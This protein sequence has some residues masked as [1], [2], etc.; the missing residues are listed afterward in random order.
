MP[1]SQFAI[2][3]H[4][5]AVLAHDGGGAPIEALAESVNTETAY[6]EGVLAS[7]ARAG[8]VEARAA[9]HGGGYVLAREAKAISLAA[10]HDALEPE[11]ESV[12]LGG[13]ATLRAA[14]R[15]VLGELAPGDDPR[16]EL[17][18]FTVADLTRMAFGEKQLPYFDARQFTAQVEETKGAVLVDFTATWCGPCQKLT[19]VLEELARDAGGKYRVVR[20]DIDDA[21][22]VA[23]KYSIRGVPTVVAFVDGKPVARNVGL[24]DAGKLRRL[25]DA[26]S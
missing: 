7:L 25:F 17:A 9:G 13:R 12:A 15:D 26:T 21:P 16:K 2:A 20:V 14:I 1:T 11:G 3:A 5:L 6:L 23:K 19:P 4:A 18:R 24:A 8:I 22:E 10:V